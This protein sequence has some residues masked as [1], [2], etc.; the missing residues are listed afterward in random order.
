[1]AYNI[2]L[3][4]VEVD[5]SAVPAIVG[6]G[7]GVAAFNVQTERGPAQRP[8]RVTTFAAFQEQFG[9]FGGPGD[10][11]YLVK[12]FFDNGGQVAWINRVTGADASA[13]RRVLQAGGAEALEVRAGIRGTQSPGAWGRGLLVEVVGGTRAGV[14]LAETA[15]ASVTGSAKLAATTD[16]SAA[17]PV[18]LV[19]DGMS[20]Q[21][22]FAP[23]AFADPKKA[24][25]E[26]IVAAINRSQRRVEASLTDEKLTLTSLGERAALAGEFS[27]IEVTAAHDP[28]NLKKTTAPV[29]GTAAAV[30]AGGTTLA[31]VAGLEPGS[32][33]RLTSGATERVV[34]LT[35]VNPTTRAVTWTPDIADPGTFANAETRARPHTF[36]LV[37]HRQGGEDLEQLERWDDLT[38]EPDLASYAPAVINDPL[39]GSRWAV[40]ID[41]SARGGA[42]ATPIPAPAA[43]AALEG[44]DAG[45]ATVRDY[46]GDAAARTGLNAFD[47]LDVQ[48]LA[49]DS[50]QGDVFD[51]A[52]AYC[53]RR[54]DCMA[55]ASVSRDTS[56]DLEG[57]IAY[58]KRYQG[59]KVY[60][61]LYG[62]WIKVMDP[63]GAGAAPVRWVPPTGHVMGVYARVSATRGIWKAPAGDEARVLGALDVELALSDTDHTALV[64]E[65]SVN[66]IRAVPGAGIVVDASRTLSTDTRWLYV[67]VRLLFNYVKTSLR[68]GL[69]WV[70]QEPNRDTLWS[71]VK[72]GTVTPFLMGLWRQGAFGTGEPDDLFTVICDASN[73]PPDQVDQGILKL[74]VYFYPSRPAETIVIIVGQQPSGSSAAEA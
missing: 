30:T 74:E 38:L 40:V 55:V 6:A 28:L 18:E 57:A 46:I 65:G 48:L 5:G 51:A 39:R 7:T 19:V 64:K 12:G 22:A 23:V 20:V 34:K 17:A 24:T 61:A 53:Q 8:R 16:L 11:A 52:L 1:M 26:E 41:D 66:G 29:R 32:P 4:V 60:G 36:G 71:A 58:G 68:Q 70:R 3:N 42:G 67:G 31:S 2:G 37:V 56:A 44:G 73:N 45:V 33:L 9:G 50:D 14:P 10:G 69:R 59:A 72:Y 62:P 21:I 25:R 15:R 54:G 27:A 35:T 43:A 13:A 63:A 47:P 49:S